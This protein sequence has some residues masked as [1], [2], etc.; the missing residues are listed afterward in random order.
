MNAS[1]GEQ[2]T[3]LVVDDADDVRTIAAQI[4]GMLDF[5]VIE[6]NG[7]E[8]ALKILREPIKVD[9]LFT[10]IAMPG[11]SGLKLAHLAKQLRPD[12][13]VL[14]TSADFF[15]GVDNPALRY[16]PLIAKPWTWAQLRDVIETLMETDKQSS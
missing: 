2:R 9:L 15:G 4:V 14:Y 1:N 12:L 5:W 16:G 13:K 3:V 7:A 11:L 8:A 6:A 10:D